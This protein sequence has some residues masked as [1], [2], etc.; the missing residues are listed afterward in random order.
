[1]EERGEKSLFGKP[2]QARKAVEE[3]DSKA[4]AQIAHVY[5]V[6]RILVLL[7]SSFHPLS[8]KNSTIITGSLSTRES[9]HRP[10]K[11]V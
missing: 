9:L 7:R 6:P 4:Q 5:P 3:G 2:A 1:V 10:R 8:G 11:P